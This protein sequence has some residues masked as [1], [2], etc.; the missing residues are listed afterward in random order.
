[1]KRL[2]FTLFICCLCLG[3]ISCKTLDIDK[4]KNNDPIQI[5]GKFVK[6]GNVPFVE[7]SLSIKEINKMFPVIF[8]TTELAEKS[9]SYIGKKVSVKGYISIKTL[10]LAD[11]SKSIKKITLIVEE[12]K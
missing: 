10:T 4:L 8:K 12:F 5:E 9:Q 1:M 3:V 11:D 6:T 7:T 2:L